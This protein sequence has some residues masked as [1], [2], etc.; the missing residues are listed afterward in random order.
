LN[1]A[2][3]SSTCDAMAVYLANPVPLKLH[4]NKITAG[5]NLGAR[6]VNPATGEERSIGALDRSSGMFTPPAGWADAFLHIKSTGA[7][8]D[9]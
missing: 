6:W 1:V 7:K 3:R 9:K 2:M 4:L 5:G 8:D